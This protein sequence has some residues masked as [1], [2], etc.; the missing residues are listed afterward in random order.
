MLANFLG[1]SKPINFIILLGL[2]ICLFLFSSF[3]L[4]LNHSFELSL[5]MK[6][7]S[8]LGLYLVIFFFFN[9]IV[10]KNNLTFDNSYAYFIFTIILS[11][12]LPIVTNP[13]TLVVLLLYILFLRKIYSLKS[14]KQPLQ[15]LFDSGFWLSILYILEPFSAMFAVL[16][17][18]AI[19]L[20]QK[21]IVNNLIAPI[22]GFLTPITLYF[23]YCFWF[24]KLYIF[25]NL[26]Y[27]E[28]F[29]SFFY[30]SEK[31]I[32][33]ISILIVIFS[34]ISIFLKS[35]KTLSVNNSF[36]KSWILLMINLVI[37][38]L[39]AFLVP[40]KNGTELLFFLFPSAIIMAN[41]LETVNK[42]LIKNI[43]FTLLFIS[44]FIF[45]F[46]L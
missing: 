3:S 19:F 40:N 13:K 9:F 21:I 12:F 27:F 28:D 43:V 44:A 20:H 4:F 2:F 24:D 46:L 38:L 6:I 37:T 25:T 5:L 41:G 34:V 30:Y 10:S 22:V 8:S 35:P 26:F 11:Y 36:K 42:N 32:Y 18:S 17:Y 1:K 45:P 39:F 16:I 31:S 23:T 29:N 14:Q 7:A 15:K 33:W